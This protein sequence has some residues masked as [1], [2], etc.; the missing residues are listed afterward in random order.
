VGKKVVM[1]CHDSV[2]S[3]AP[4][5]PVELFQRQ[6]AKSVDNKSPAEVGRFHPFLS[7]I[8]NRKNELC[9]KKGRKVWFF[10][11]SG[12]SCAAYA[13]AIP[14]WMPCQVVKPE[15]EFPWGGEAI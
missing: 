7:Q 15:K 14:T 9:V 4:F 8:D 5:S 3:I 11:I 12:I 1:L 2:E 10:D 6:R 13:F